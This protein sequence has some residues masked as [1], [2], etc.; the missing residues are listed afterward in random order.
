MKQPD[1]NTRSDYDFEP[2]KINY[3][4]SEPNMTRSIRSDINL[5]LKIDDLSFSLVI[6][7]LTGH[8]SLSV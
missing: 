8:N 4:L 7:I 3:E 5:N 6:M 1:K 2:I